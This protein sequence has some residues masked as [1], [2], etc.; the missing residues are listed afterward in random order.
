[1]GNVTIIKYAGGTDDIPEHEE[2]VLFWKCS[3]DFN[4]GLKIAIDGVIFT[5]NRVP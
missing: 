3:F 1:M 2:C 5:F 4:V